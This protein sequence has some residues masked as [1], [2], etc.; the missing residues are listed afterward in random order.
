[1]QKNSYSEIFLSCFL[2]IFVGWMIYANSFN[3]PFIFDDLG[4]AV[5]NP[6]IEQLWPLWN[7]FVWPDNC[8]VSGRPVVNLSLTINYALGG[9]DVWGYHVFNL[10]AHI[11]CSLVLFGVI[12]RT[13]QME[14]IPESIKKSALPL[15]LSSSLLWLA[16]PIQTECINY[17]IQRTEIIMALFYLLTFYCSIRS[18]NSHYS[19]FWKIMA[20]IFCICGMGSK[21]V[22]VTA[23]FMIVLYDLIFSPLPWRKLLKERGQFYACLALTW[24]VLAALIME[25]PR[26][27]S[28]GF[29]GG[30]SPLEYAMNQCI[31]VI[32]Y[33]RL[34]FFPYPLVLDYGGTV[35]VTWG[36]A[37]PSGILLLTLLALVVGTLYKLPKI[38][39]LGVWVFVILSP[40]SSFVPIITEVAA[41]RRMYLPL[42]AMIVLLVLLSY[43]S[44]LWIKDKVFSEENRENFNIRLV[45]VF[46][47]TTIVGLMSWASIMRSFDYSTSEQIWVSS[48]KAYPKNKR[49]KNNLGVIYAD[50]GRYEKAILYYKQALELDPKYYL[51]RENLGVAYL[52]QKKAQDALTVFETLVAERGENPHLLTLCGMAQFELGFLDDAI[53]N[54][55]KAVRAGYWKARHHLKKAMKKKKSLE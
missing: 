41:E 12:R 50:W 35:P 27:A 47:V 9:S 24:F 33:F 45:S 42:A 54:Y 17:I 55:Q 44:L 22:M 49:A 19:R 1:M 3:N 25:G 30:V 46:L 16:H 2:L 40:S 6:K 43:F 23:P 51:S 53:D 10:I 4:V 15:A 20:V 36:E 7:M 13:L 52:K 39:F 32:H 11:L 18:Q 26:A 21:E 29:S 8:A 37:A 14:N 48:I 31:F 38:G 34:V 5:D 28:V